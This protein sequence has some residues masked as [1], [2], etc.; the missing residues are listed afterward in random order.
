MPINFPLHYKKEGELKPQ[1]ILECVNA[2]KTPELIVATDVGQHQM[3][4]AQYITSTKPRS[5]ISSGGLGTMGF[6]FPAAIGA[7][8]G[9]PDRIVF[10]IAGDGSFQMV[11]QELAT[12]VINHIPVK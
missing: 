8:V 7:Q 11:S 12:A 9:R 1:Y 10:D 5:F 2:L 6:G 4:A 3:W